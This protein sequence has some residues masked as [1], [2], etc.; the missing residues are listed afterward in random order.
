MFGGMNDNDKKTLL[1]AGLCAGVT[2]IVYFFFKYMLYLVAPFLA[3]LILAVLIN[4]PVSFM[5]RKF[6]IH[7]IIGT[8]F[9]I[10]V[11]TAVFSF[12]LSYVGTRFI[13]E[14]K[15]FMTNYPIYYEKAVDSVCEFCCTMDNTLGMEE[16]W[17]YALVERNV[18]KTLS[19]AAD[20]MLPSL[21]E[22]SA[23]V[24]SAVVMW[25]GGIVIAI[26]SVFFMIKDVD[27]MTDWVKNGSYSKWF[28]IFFGRLSRFGAAYLKT[29]FV[30][31]AIT[32]V[33]CTFAMYLIGNGYPIMIGILIGLLDALPLFG[34]G[35]VLIPWTIIYLFTGKF[36]KAA[37][38]FTAY[39][40]CYVVR[41]ILEPKMMGGHMGIP[42]VVMLITMYIG[43][44]LFGI[45][46]FILG[47]A[48]YI[49]VVEV[50]AYL[51]KVI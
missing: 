49:I 10:A 22:N 38:V 36:Y 42:P 15:K 32:A 34:T 2:G 47:P 29:Q 37:I 20:N 24:I 48:A 40:V 25:G 26:T 7:P 8:I 14:L 35:T 13:F 44:L 9:V 23:G 12:W 21:M 5:N 19:K 51:K 11:A 17:T 45:L 16:G 6:K 1:L 33:I 41:E 31:M 30:I 46:G 27:K 4:K 43:I 50:T 39:A 28:R 18:S 3:G